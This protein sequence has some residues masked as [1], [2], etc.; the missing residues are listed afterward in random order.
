MLFI[1]SLRRCTYVE[2]RRINGINNR[3]AWLFRANVFIFRARQG[4]K[5]MYRWF[6]FHFVLLTSDSTQW[7][8]LWYTKRA[9]VRL[10]NLLMPIS[11]RRC[12]YVELRR[13]NGINNKTKWPG[14]S[15]QI[16]WF[17]QSDEKKGDVHSV[18]LCA[19]DSLV[20]HRTETRCDKPNMQWWD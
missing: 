4:R 17:F 18:S 11:L 7:N 1:I 8:T 5:E 10:V 20:T 2:I 19:P 6:H 15:V 12:A 9:V 14:Y 13:V 16:I 3:M